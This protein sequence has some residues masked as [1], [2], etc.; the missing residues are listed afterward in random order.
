LVQ[1]WLTP[2]RKYE[3]HDEAL[4]WPAARPMHGVHDLSALFNIVPAM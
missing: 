1:T 4:R 3:W 2:L